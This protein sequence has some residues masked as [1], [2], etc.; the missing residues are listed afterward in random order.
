[1]PS[2]TPAAIQVD[3]TGP[4]KFTLVVTFDGQRF[5]CGN[6]ISRAAAMQAGRL[7]VQRKEGEAE[8]RRGRTRKKP[9]KG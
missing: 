4:Q 8:G 1:M 6:Y 2:E 3:E 9:A 7:F 5:D